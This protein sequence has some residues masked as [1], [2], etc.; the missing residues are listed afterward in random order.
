MSTTQAVDAA[1]DAAL[2][3]MA[4]QIAANLAYLP[5][6][7]AADTVAG[8]LRSFWTPAMRVALQRLATDEPASLDPLVLAAV[9][10]LTHS[11]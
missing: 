3:R 10:D 5:P 6:T 8:H 7:E 1:N 2:V 9:E 4:N 11:G